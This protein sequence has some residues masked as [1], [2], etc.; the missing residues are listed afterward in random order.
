MRKR[1]ITRRDF[2]TK[3]GAVAAG[4]VA[5][6]YIIPSSALGKDGAVAPSNRIVMGAIGTGGQGTGNMMQFTKNPG[7]QMVAAC[8]VDKGHLNQAKQK[9]DEHYGDK[10]C[11]VYGDFREL[12]ARDDIEIKRVSEPGGP[13]N[14][15][16]LAAV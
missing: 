12:L 14:V 15:I 5:F 3:T 10:G 16:S 2:L 6:P 4:A 8:D 7:S 9:V 1:S 11:A 13:A